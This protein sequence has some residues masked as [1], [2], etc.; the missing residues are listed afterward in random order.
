[1]GVSDNKFRVFLVF[2]D[3]SSYGVS[4]M[5][6]VT[7][8][9]LV[10]YV[11]KKLKL[12]NEYVFSFYYKLSHGS[13]QIVD[14][15]DV[16]F[17]VD[18]VCRP[19]AAL[20]KL[21]IK[22]VVKKVKSRV[23]Q[24][25][26][27]P[28]DFDLNDTVFPN[29]FESSAFCNDFEMPKNEP[30]ENYNEFNDEYD[31]HSR[32]TFPSPERF[33]HKWEETNIFQNMPP[34]PD[35]PLPDLKELLNMNCNSNSSRILKAGD[36]FDDKSWCMFEIGKKALIDGRQFRTRKSD[37]GRYDVVCYHAGCDWKIVT[38]KIRNS[39]KFRIGS[40]N[41]VHTC[42]KTQLLPHHR[43][44][45]IKLLGRL[46]APKLRDS[47]RIYKP[48]DIKDDLAEAFNI[49][50]SYKK[51][52][53]G[54]NRALEIL[55]GCPTDSFAQLPYYFHNLEMANDGWVT[56]IDSDDEGRFKMCFV[57]FGVAA[58]KNYAKD[59]F[60]RSIGAIQAYKPEAYNKLIEAGVERWSRAWCPAKRYNY[61]TSNSAESINALTKDV[62]RE[63]ITRFMDWYR[64]LLQRW[65]CERR[66]KYEDAVEGELSD[67]A[68]KKLNQRMIKSANW[69]VTGIQ[70]N[71]LYQVVDFRKHHIVDLGSWTCTCCQWQFSG[72][73][74]GHA[75]AV[76][77]FLKQT[78]CNHMVSYWFKTT[79]LKGTYQGLVYPVGSSTE[80]EKPDGLQIVKPPGVIKPQSGRPKNKDRIKSQGELPTPVTCTRCWQPGHKREACRQPLPKHN[81]NVGNSIWR[82]PSIVGN[83]FWQHPYGEGTSNP[84]QPS[85]E[86]TS[87]WVQPS[88]AGTIGWGQPSMEGTSGSYQYDEMDWSYENYNL[89]DP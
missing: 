43:N 1:M 46:I 35:Q 2:E 16:H 70:A 89:A 77:R 40:I 53:A 64:G 27:K 32:P 73:P 51:A 36:E 29:D 44:A 78:D 10:S 62:R 17:F 30:L 65:Y 38:S 11:D 28:L 3:G 88:M 57:A 63:P 45:T 21:F 56:H 47:S 49:D 41:D 5:K 58:C 87:G 13:V 6:N 74:C 12:N 19:K 55:S 22:K 37:K 8:D 79:T 31:N 81:E 23:K 67:W 42:P 68:A 76:S 85:M 60:Q 59:D 9:G 48:R 50:V 80:W 24:S 39:V 7:Y 4:L 82:H 66:D 72:I 14:D 25:S 34:I 26:S 15:D 52:W 71:I 61:M 69:V 83:S 18:E 84:G 20:P 54:K 75:I 33:V 86:G